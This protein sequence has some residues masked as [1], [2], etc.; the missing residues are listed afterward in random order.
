M[1]LSEYHKK[2]A[3]QSNEEIQQKTDAKSNELKQVFSR[4]PF[5]VN[6]QIVKIAVLGCGERRL[7]RNHKEIFELVLNKPV[8][9]TTFDITTEHLAD[10]PGVIEHDVTKSIPGGPYDIIYAHVLLKFI[11][12]EKQWDVIMN[13][14]NCL[15]SSGVAL[16]F[17]DE[18]ELVTDTERL[19]KWGWS[20]PLE[21]WKDR[22]IESEIDYRI[23]DIVIRGSLGR[24]LGVVVLALLKP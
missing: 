22:L 15:N 4:I 17:F 13:S 6:R 9:L 8:E 5:I 2:F 24:P 14:Y 7:A 11:E 20:V 16:H 18:E 3:A 23:L 21:R 10:V 12:I 19:G 1:A